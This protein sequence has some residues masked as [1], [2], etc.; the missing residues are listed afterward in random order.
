MKTRPGW[1]GRRQV[2]KAAVV[3]SLSTLSPFD[4]GGIPNLWAAPSASRSS[5]ADELWTE[6]LDQYLKVD[7]SFDYR[8]LA[9]KSAIRFD[10]LMTALQPSQNFSSINHQRAFFINAYN[11]LCVR[12]IVDA[13]V[14]TKMPEGG[15]FKKSLYERRD[16]RIDGRP[17]S[18]AEIEKTI[19]LRRHPDPRLVGALFQGTNNGPGL[20]R[21]PFR[22][23][24]L[25]QD[26]TQAAEEFLRARQPG[27]SGQLLN[28]LDRK[29]KVLTVSPAF[30]RLKS[31][32]PQEEDV[33]SFFARYGRK[34][35]REFLK[36]HRIELKFASSSATIN[37]TKK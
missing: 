35:E 11:I 7:G 17:L 21:S 15:L 26:L 9:K 14:P 27:S 1:A 23:Q 13:G 19:L 16:Y 33:L 20:A 37:Q 5:I 28:S 22:A 4:T 8:G 29:K 18:I 31:I 25:G 36:S 34:S 24:H 6:L 3:G 10:A 2:L 32:F 12:L 30:R